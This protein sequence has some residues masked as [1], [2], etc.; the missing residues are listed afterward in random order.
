MRWL[1]HTTHRRTDAFSCSEET[2]R[3]SDEVMWQCH[4]PMIQ[5]QDVWICVFTIVLL[6]LFCTNVSTAHSQLC[7]SWICTVYRIK[8]NQLPSSS[9]EM[10]R[11]ASYHSD[12]IGVDKDE[13]YNKQ[14]DKK[15]EQKYK[16]ETCPVPC[17]SWMSFNE[18]L[19]KWE[20]VLVV[21]KWKK[22]IEATR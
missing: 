6:L 11:H 14:K 22:C 8:D 3:I 9:H 19:F 2:M 5:G 20:C 10:Q 17:F 16:Y 18:K 13:F 12:A 15:K 4:E 1:F 7:Y 21:L